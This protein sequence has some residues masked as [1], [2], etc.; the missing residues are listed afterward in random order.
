M[1][2]I[3]FCIILFFNFSNV[4]S[5]ETI[6][7]LDIEFILNN[8]NSGK[9]I[10]EELEKINSKNIS[11]LKIQEEELKNLENNI[12]KV[13]NIIS[14]EELQNKVENLKKKNNSL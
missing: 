8:S 10:I 4:L 13:K 1:K 12:S 7:F 11:E 9:I 14:E 3:F 6:H 2:K 5:E